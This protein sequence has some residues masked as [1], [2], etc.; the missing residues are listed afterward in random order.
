MSVRVVARIRPLLNTE[1]ELDTVVRATGS[2]NIA[3]SKSS[4]GSAAKS[5]KLDTIKI[6]NPKN[7]AEEHSFQFGRVYGSQAVQSEIFDEEG[8]YTSLVA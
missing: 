3:T 5:E 1:R 7:E 8:R 6:T 2:A 4:S